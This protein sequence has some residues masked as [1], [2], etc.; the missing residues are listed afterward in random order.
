MLSIYSALTSGLFLFASTNK[1]TDKAWFSIVVLS[2]I[3]IVSL[4]SLDKF[5]DYIASGQAQIEYVRELKENKQITVVSS[6][7]IT[8]K[9]MKTV[10]WLL[11]FTLI[12]NV[13]GAA[14]YIISKL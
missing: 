13:T 7:D 12:V 9:V 14:G 1:I 5:L 6:N 2:S 10:P 11:I 3:L 8:A 4:C